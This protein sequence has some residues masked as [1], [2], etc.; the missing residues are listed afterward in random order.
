[1]DFSRLSRE[2]VREY[3]DLVTSLRSETRILLG[4]NRILLVEAREVAA[5]DYDTRRIAE[6]V[7]KAHLTI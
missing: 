3:L 2:D 7:S 1:V 5:G 4:L 6:A